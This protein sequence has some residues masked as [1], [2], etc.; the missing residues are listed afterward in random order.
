[1][2]WKIRN[3]FRYILPNIPKYWAYNSQST[4]IV[5]KPKY[6][7]I[8]FSHQKFFFNFIFDALSPFVDYVIWYVPTLQILYTGIKDTWSSN[9]QSS[10]KPYTLSSS[11]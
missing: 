5:S 10:F 1:M 4:Q 7:N 6:K 2:L 9:L 11:I 3:N 8:A